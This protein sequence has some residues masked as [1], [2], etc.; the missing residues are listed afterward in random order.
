M[1]EA[2]T[3]VATMLEEEGDTETGTETEEGTAATKET[4]D[5]DPPD[6]SHW[7]NVVELV[8]AIFWEGRLYEDS[9]WRFTT[10][11]A[12]HDVLHGFWAGRSTGTVSL[13]ANLLYKL[14]AMKEEVLYKIFLELHKAYNAL[15]RDGRLEILEG[16]IV[17]PRAHR[18][19]HVYWDRLKIDGCSH[20]R[21][22]RG[23]VL[24]FLGGDPG[25]PA[26]PHCFKY[27]GGNI[28]ASMDIN[29][30]GRRGSS[31]RV[32]EGG[33]SLHRLLL[34]RQ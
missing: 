20:R 27:G 30:G 19:L 9:T 26:F 22:L 5:T 24:R 4:K 34:R 21:L 1:E 28:D 23:G 6:L 33:D 13:K 2:T 7:K 32:G 15:D 16:Y 11:I 17:R 3:A 10:S 31:G 25:G 12:F 14:T 29:G 8:K 18:I